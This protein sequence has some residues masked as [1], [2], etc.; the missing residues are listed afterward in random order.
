MYFC[1]LEALQNVAK[2]ANASRATV[3]VRRDDGHLRF[4]VSD[5]GV[6]FD[7]NGSGAGTGLQGKL[8]LLCLLYSSGSFSPGGISGSGSDSTKSCANR[9]RKNW[10]SWIASV[11]GS[12]SRRS[13]T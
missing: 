3:S 2:Y 11:A 1:T 10:S 8:S 5:D 13:S 4:Y 7:T 12:G 6:G 9:P